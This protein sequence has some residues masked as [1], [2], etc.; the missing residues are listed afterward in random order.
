MMPAR[1]GGATRQRIA[2]DELEECTLRRPLIRSPQS[3]AIFKRKPR[4]NPLQATVLRQ[5]DEPGFCG[6]ILQSRDKRTGL[7]RREPQPKSS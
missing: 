1:R 3:V 7:V 6:E 4:K 2:G 5:G